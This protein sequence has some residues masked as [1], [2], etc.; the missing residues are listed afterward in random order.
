MIFPHFIPCMREILDTSSPTSWNPTISFS[1][2]GSLPAMAQERMEMLWVKVRKITR[3]QLDKTLVSQI[4][5]NI[6][7]LHFL[8]KKRN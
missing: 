8:V 3:F 1:E 2:Y 4:Y 5:F 6:K 7:S